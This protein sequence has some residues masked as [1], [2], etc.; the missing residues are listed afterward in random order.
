M[1]AICVIMQPIMLMWELQSNSRNRHETFSLQTRWQ[2]NRLEPNELL[3]FWLLLS[4]L[5]FCCSLEPCCQSKEMNCPG[6]AEL[7]LG[8]SRS[9]LFPPPPLRGVPD[10]LDTGS[11]ELKTGPLSSWHNSPCLQMI[12]FGKP[13]LTVGCHWCKRRGQVALWWLQYWRGDSDAPEHH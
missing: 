6:C 3:P 9:C 12:F 10:K 11:R 5:L 13:A 8:K 1:S 2:Q 4:S 7:V